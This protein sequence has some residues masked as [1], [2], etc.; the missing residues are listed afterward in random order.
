MTSDSASISRLF[1]ILV[2]GG[3]LALLSST[4]T[5]VALPQILADLGGDIAS[6]QWVTTAYM[7]AAGLAI[8]VASWAGTRFGLRSTWLVAMALFALGSIACLFVPDVGSL[9]V[10]RAIQGLGGGALE[11][12]MV[13]TLAA[14]TPPNRMGRTMGAMGVVMEIGPLLGPTI[15]GA[16]VDAIGW[17]SIYLGFAL[18]AAAMMTAGALMLWKGERHSAPLDIVGL[19]VVSA[20]LVAGLW[21]LARAATPAGFDLRTLATLAFAAAACF[22]FVRRGHHLGARSIVNLGTFARPGFAP[23]VTI[24]ALLGAKIFPLFFSLPQFYQGVGHLSPLAAGMLMI[25]YGIGTLS[26]MPMMG[27][28]SDR[29][30]AQRIVAAGAALSLLAFTTLF[31]AGSSLPLSGLAGLSLLTGVGLGAIA[32][33]TVATMYRVLTPELTSSGSTILFI[34]LQLGGAFGVAL[35]ALLIGHGTWTAAVGTWP[36]LLSIVTALAIAALS[37][38]LKGAPPGDGR[39]P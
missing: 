3:L 12:L 10:A 32:S 5:G 33:P 13:T 37:T 28:L 38:R 11:P 19:T 15:G 39:A 30:E 8:P 4:V 23:G 27:Y 7:L 17:R 6:G 9:S 31:L 2:S 18:A 35:I 26:T 29:L 36:F 21:G 14:A 24:M 34:I 1:A 22:G 16:A 20:G 25:P